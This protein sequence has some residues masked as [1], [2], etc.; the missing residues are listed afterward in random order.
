MCSSDISVGGF[1]PFTTIDF[2]I[3]DSACVVFCQGCNWNCV[4]CQNKELQENTNSFEK[5][6]WSDTFEQIRNRVNFLD[7]VVFSGGEPLLQKN[8][9]GAIQSVKNLGLK[10][11]IH[12]SGT[13]PKG[14]LRLIPYLD[15][16]GL[17]IKAPFH[18]YDKITGVKASGQ[19][20]KESLEVLSQNN[21][22]YECRTTIFPN[23]ISSDDVKE[24]ALELKRLGVEKFAIQQCLDEDRQPIF[25]EC[26]KESFLEELKEIYP[27][28]IIRK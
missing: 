17:D 25:S 13:N 3:V 18:K 22:K 26:F 28:L 9:L 27:N 16:V 10:V 12:T 24:I 21:I 8:L 6:S 7:G 5:I 15:W 19:L 4:Y 1:L 20:A 11:G 2:P 23:L 14:L